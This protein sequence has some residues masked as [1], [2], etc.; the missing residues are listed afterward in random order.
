[1]FHELLVS[2]FNFVIQWGF[3]GVVVLMALESTIIPIPSEVV[4]PPAA[5]LIASNQMTLWGGDSMQIGFWGVVFAGTLGSYL[6]SVVSYG[7]SRSLGRVVVIRW[8]KYFLLS[9]KKLEKAEH[10]MRRYEAGGIFFARLL[11][12]IR[13]LI[14]IPAGLIRMPFGMFSLMTIVGSFAWC[15]VLAWL[16]VQAQKVQPNLIEDPEALVHFIKGQAHWIVLGIAALAAL[17]FLVLKL[18]AKAE[19][20]S[21]ESAE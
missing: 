11:P 3:V 6:G 4:V 15:W 19:K 10:W 7:V 16:G 14:S 20:K 12:G 1:M 2:W 5:F 13:H 8:G 18:T 9:E 21:E 17:Y